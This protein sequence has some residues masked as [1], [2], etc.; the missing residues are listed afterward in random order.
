MGALLLIIFLGIILA[1]SLALWLVNPPLAQAAALESASG[2]VEVLAADGWQAAAPG[3]TLAAG[4]GLR[5][6]PDGQAVLALPDGSRLTL[7]AGAEIKL[8]QLNPRWLGR[9]KLSQASGVTQHNV[10]RRFGG[11]EVASPAGVIRAEGTR[12][13][14]AVAAGGWTRLDVQHGAVS[15]QA[16]AERLR[17]SAGQAVAAVPQGALGEP[18]YQFSLRGVVTRAEAGQWTV[19]STEFEVAPQTL[20]EAS[21]GLGAQVEVQGRWLA[22]GRRIADRVISQGPATGEAASFTGLLQSAGEEAWQVGGASLK[23]NAATLQLGKPQA[24]KPVEVAYIV[25]ANGE[26]LALEVQPLDEPP[27]EPT[28]TATLPPGEPTPTVTATPAPAA[29]CTGAN[30]HP[31]G[32]RLAARYGV[33]YEEIMGWFCQGFGFGEI[34]LAYGLSRQAGV[35]AGQIF[36]LRV[37]GLG[38]GEIKQLVAGGLITPTP[39]ISP[40]VTVTPTIALTP[41]ITPT[42]TVTPTATIT[43][44]ATVTPI[45]TATPTPEPTRPGNP[46]Q[47]GTIHPEGQRLAAAYGVPY[48]E[49]IGWFCRG[50][51]FGEIKLAYDLSRQTGTPVAQIFAMRA[52]GMGWGEI[53]QQLTS[54]PP[55][56]SGKPTKQPKPTRPPKP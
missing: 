4:Q 44:T 3:Q 9:I 7:Q 24:G 56:Q 16:G 32:T 17:L 11:Y 45:L 8:D 30:P 52:S 29:I 20:V 5:A 34:D 36:A 14:V 35:S 51:G 38:W 50:Y 28:P 43:P 1:G 22:D 54:G 23:V 49:I 18:A 27:D 53:K 21:T 26:W 47:P 13:A 2:Q 55:G 31:T 10:A 37:S 12:F 48:S 15:L 33:S 19:E 42:V 39:V 25:M 40:T 6:G 41:T 46:C